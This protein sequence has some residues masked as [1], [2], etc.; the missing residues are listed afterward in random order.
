MKQRRKTYPRNTAATYTIDFTSH[1]I[2][3]ANIICPSSV[4]KYT[5]TVVPLKY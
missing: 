4:K 1:H 5:V 3:I 2:A